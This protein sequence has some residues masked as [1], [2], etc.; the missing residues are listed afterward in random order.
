MITQPTKAAHPGKRRGIEQDEKP[1]GKA[2]D[3]LMAWMNARHYVDGG[4][5]A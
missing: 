4:Q 5:Y 1:I 2:P 3:A